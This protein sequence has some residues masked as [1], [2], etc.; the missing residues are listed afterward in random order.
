MLTLHSSKF[1]KNEILFNEIDVR[2]SGRIE[3]SALSNAIDRVMQF[4]LFVSSPDDLT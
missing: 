4:N 2:R 1:H 3:V